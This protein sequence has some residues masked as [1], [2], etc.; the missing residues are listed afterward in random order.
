MAGRI[1]S[2]IVNDNL[3]LLLD[4]M[5]PKSYIPSATTWYDLS[6]NNNHC[7][8]N[9]GPSYSTDGVSSIY[10]DGTNDTGNIAISS[11]LNITTAVSVCIWVKLGNGTNN[12]ARFMLKNPGWNTFLGIRGGDGFA[13]WYSNLI[14][15]QVGYSGIFNNGPWANLVY[16][17]DSAVVGN[18]MKCYVNGILKGQTTV[19]GTLTSG[20]STFTVATSSF[21]GWIGNAS[22]YD[23]AL[24]LNEINQNY[25]AKKLI[26]GL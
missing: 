24:S 26:Y 12:Y 13:I 3:V 16:T 23:K 4:A 18:N 25:N 22:L 6:G 20:A 11:T 7:T 21:T 17:Y 9:N 5:N 10:F 19:T 2:N 14:N 15:W 1:S 8:L